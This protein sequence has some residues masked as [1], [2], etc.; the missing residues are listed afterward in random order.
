[1]VQIQKL[2]RSQRNKHHQ[3]AEDEL[4]VI[5]VVHPELQDITATDQDS[6]NEEEYGLID[7]MNH[8]HLRAEAELAQG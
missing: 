5:F 2:F 7:T 3:K 8:Y 6:A 4:P 1:M